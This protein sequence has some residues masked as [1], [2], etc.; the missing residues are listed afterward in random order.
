MRGNWDGKRHFRP[1]CVP[2]CLA[3][4]VTPYFMLV[5]NLD[6]L[7]PIKLSSPPQALTD[8]QIQLYPIMT[9]VPFSHLSL[10][11][12]FKSLLHIILSFAGCAS[13]SF[14]L[15]HGFDTEIS[16]ISLASSVSHSH[17]E[18]QQD[19]A[20]SPSPASVH[21]LL[22]N[23]N[24][25]FS[26][27]FHCLTL[28]YKGSDAGTSTLIVQTPPQSFHHVHAQHHLVPAFRRVRNTGAPAS[29]S[30]QHTKENPDT[31]QHLRSC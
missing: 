25:T 7:D 21:C 22:P 23:H 20:H 29:H 14:A 11:H 18:G 28:I 3:P 8:S 31:R 13:Q 19:K 17:V 10:F 30:F 4:Y 26:S 24:T 12:S 5:P 27:L 6:L 15:P 1:L 9:H 16:K 2:P